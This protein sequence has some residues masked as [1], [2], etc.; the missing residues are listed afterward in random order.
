MIKRKK[1]TIETPSWYVQ[2]EYDLMYK[3]L[4]LPNLYWNISERLSLFETQGM[5][6][7]PMYDCILFDEFRYHE[8]SILDFLERKEGFQYYNF[9]DDV[10]KEFKRITEKKILEMDKETQDAFFSDK[11]RYHLSTLHDKSLDLPGL[12]PLAYWEMNEEIDRINCL[13]D[14]EP[15][16]IENTNRAN[17]KEAN[18]DEI[19]IA[20]LGKEVEPGY[21]GQ[22]IE[23]YSFKSF[24][25]IQQLS[26]SNRNF[27]HDYLFT[28]NPSDQNKQVDVKIDLSESDNTLK[29]SFE[30]LLASLR[31]RLSI[32]DK[33]CR[34][35][36]MVNKGGNYLELGDKVLNEFV[37]Y[38]VFE[39]FDLMFWAMLT[40]KCYKYTT[41]QKILFEDKATSNS[42]SYSN[43]RAK[44]LIED[45]FLLSR[46]GFKSIESQAKAYIKYQ[47]FSKN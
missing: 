2:E 23:G 34:D 21:R 44:E 9:A 20:R 14:N 17:Y 42:P 19:E 6:E 37:K 27:I 25:E 24:D 26:Q 29:D 46:N 12:H 45:Y 32:E 4:D 10:D 22:F 40:N 43:T 8:G 11:V 30:K 47:A 33:K 3:K 38:R 35:N 18:A 16:F 13:I 5:K 7:P 39:Y 28:I 41:L 31:K 1:Y 15:N 36:L